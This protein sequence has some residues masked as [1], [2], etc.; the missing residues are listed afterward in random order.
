MSSASRSYA[1]PALLALSA[2][3]ALSAATAA[4]ARA[5]DPAP[6]AAAAVPA[7]D[8]AAP[9]AAADSAARTAAAVRSSEVVVVSRGSTRSAVSLGGPE[10][11]KILPG[12]SPLQALETLPG[13][14]Y[15]TADP[16]GNNE[17]NTLLFIHGFSTQQLGFTLDG[18]PLGDQQY[19]NYNG[20]S[21]QRAVISEDVG[22][23]TLESGAGDLGAASTSNLGGVV[24]TFTAAPLRER[25]LDVRQTFG[26]YDTFR[27]Y[28]RADT[29][30]F[31]NGNSAYVAYARQDQR[32][33]DFNGH[34]GGNQ[35]NAKFQHE[36]ERGKLTVYL[37]LDD[38]TEPNE[39]SIV[40]PNRAVGGATVQTSTD[41]SEPY[42]RPFLYP[43]L[44]AAL[45]YLGANGA[46][47][48]SAGNNF[49]N[50]HS[51]AQRTDV[52]GYAK[53]DYTVNPD[54]TWSNQIYFH[55]DEGRGIVAGPI[56]Q[57]G[58]PALFAVYYPGQDLKSVFGGSGYAVRTTE[59]LINR[60]GFI[61]TLNWR[62]GSHDIEGGLWYER[63]SSAT[64]R[65]WYS[66]A[67]SSTDLTPYD[68]PTNKNFAQYA[69]Q[70]DNNVA[71]FH[72]QDQWRVLHDLVLQ[73]GFKSSLQWARGSVPIQQRNL[74]G[75][76][77]AAQT[78]L[79]TGEIDTLEGFLPQFGALYDLTSHEQVFANIQKNLRQFITYG[80][81]GLSP[82]S[83]GSQAAFDL[84][85]QNTDP[86]HSWTYEGGLRSHR[87]LNFGPLTGVDAQVSYYH[88]DF[89]NRLLQISATPVIGSL[90]SGAAIIANVG[91]VKTDGVDL[92][93][94]LRFGQH[95]AVYDAVSYNRSVYQDNYAT[96]SGKTTVTVP[97]EGKNV[98]ASPDWLN[99][100]VVSAN[101]GPFEG[102]LTGDY[103][104]RR[105][106]TYTNDLS[107]DPYLLLG[108]EAS[109]SFEL[110]AATR[111]HG[112]RVSV[113]VTNLADT[114]GDL[115]V[116]V[117]QP[118]G[119]YNTYSIP[120]R[121]VF[122]TVQAKF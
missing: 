68:T 71:Q 21:P 48:A 95:F 7:A 31:G 106:A 72:L 103:V 122:V 80:A 47:P 36:D 20:L 63:N 107:V 35:L 26:S 19:G 79:P 55:H 42:T 81:G 94:T 37:D 112:A 78:N 40:H 50:Y 53:Y 105:Y 91:S 57:A 115:E 60:G 97:T 74:P 8:P 117:G 66:F 49:S 89:S 6:A 54:I 34:Q 9:Q 61:S 56:N 69:S 104:G 58:L 14:L 18:V 16:W 4:A 120:P 44:P 67:A 32:A 85:K 87:A 15:V 11:Q 121:Q 73:A 22:R 70:I 82:W 64:Q 10:I 45:A 65:A 96:Q 83:L 41:R 93:G 77:L 13:V 39:D 17:Q 101:F 86:E 111:L 114:Q 43:D 100:F 23:V 2:G 62:L 84:F 38:K 46:P 92:A 102:Q 99:K 98:P 25:G 108:L 51:A 75:L 5:A 28:V 59:Y 76:A 52:L 30:L 27:T 118:S 24:G 88:V 90:V 3:L 1:R 113:N 29:G 12:L 110:P 33:W 116:L 109:Y 119:T